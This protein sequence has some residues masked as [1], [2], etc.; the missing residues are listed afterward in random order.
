MY[1]LIQVD[2]C[3]LIDCTSSMLPWINSVKYSIKSLE[4]KMR[5]T[6]KQCKMR[7]AF[8]RYTDY[9]Q[10]VESRIS[11]FDFTRLVLHFTTI[12]SHNRKLNSS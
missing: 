4:S 3:F 10:P 8:V 7:F 6:H 2:V 12:H 9:D 11:W 1:F 5:E